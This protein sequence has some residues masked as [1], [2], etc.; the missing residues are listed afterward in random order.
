VT[1]DIVNDLHPAR[2]PAEFVMMGWQDMLAAFGMGLIL[3][4]L[5]VT[6][7]QPLLRQRSRPQRTE[8][9]IAAAATLPPAERLLA[10]SALLTD[11]GRRLPDDLRHALYSGAPYDPARA[12]A[13]IR[14]PKNANHG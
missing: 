9:R 3:A 2:L 8:D 4:G 13:L 11:R 7:L 6:L 5:I 1:P 10:L 12:E 14:T